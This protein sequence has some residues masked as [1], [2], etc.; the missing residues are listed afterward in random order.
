MILRVISH[1]EFFEGE[2][3]IINLL[4][5][6]G[7]QYFHLRKPGLSTAQ[8]Q[9]FIAKLPEGYHAKIIVHGSPDLQVCSTLGGLHIPEWE[10]KRTRVEQIEESI[11]QLKKAQKLV[12][13]SVHQL[14]HMAD[15]HPTYD[16]L[17]LSPL[18]SSIS[19]PDYRSDENWE[20]QD[21][22]YRDKLV[23]L[24]GIDT[25]KI[26]A[27]AQLGF[28]QVAVLGAIWEEPQKA[29]E[30]FKQLKSVCESA[31]LTY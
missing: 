12:G 28:R 27:A 21:Y 19:K 6:A 17:M 10:R 2:S 26:G 15:L 13:T 23:G 22:A 30:K 24:G 5:E 14:S 31:A 1:P 18:F 7:M 11:K 9:A 8:V 25:D 20:I 4:F 3:E 29:L 16:Y